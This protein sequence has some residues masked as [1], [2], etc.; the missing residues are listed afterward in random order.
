M[1]RLR[2][3]YSTQSSANELAQAVQ[4]WLENSDPTVLFR[5]CM[6]CHNS[7]HKTAV[8]RKFNVVPPVAV[9]TGRTACDHYSDLEDI[10]F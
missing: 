10:P 3:S 2:S 7:D 9:I 5:T 4:A 8:C 1:P 6:T